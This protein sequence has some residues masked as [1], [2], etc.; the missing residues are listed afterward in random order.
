MV[1]P[2]PIYDGFRKSGEAF[3]CMSCGHRYPSEAETP[4]LEKRAKP[5]V[6]SEAD[7]PVIPDIFA[8]EERHHCCLYCKHYVTSPF[9]QRCG[10]TNQKTEAINLCVRFEEPPEKQV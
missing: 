9:D 8:H 7:K 5:S 1:R 4:F 2:E 6:F 10:L 3:V